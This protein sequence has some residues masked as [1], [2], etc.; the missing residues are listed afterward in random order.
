MWNFYLLGCA[1]VF[2]LCDLQLWQLLLSKDC[3][4]LPK[5]DCLI[6]RE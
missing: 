6:K 2:E 4:D 3:I 5:R 1:A